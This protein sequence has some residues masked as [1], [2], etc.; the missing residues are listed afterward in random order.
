MTEDGTIDAGDLRLPGASASREDDLNLEHLEAR[1]IRE[2]LR[3][4]RGAIGTAA[5]ILGV[6]RDT[7]STKMK[8]YDISKAGD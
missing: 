6:H 1:A 8:K 3:R 4:S 2:A 5:D 7:L